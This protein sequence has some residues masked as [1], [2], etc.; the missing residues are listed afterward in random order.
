MVEQSVFFPYR[1]S[2]AGGFFPH[3]E[4]IPDVVVWHTHPGSDGD[5]HSDGP[6]EQHS[7]NQVQ[8]PGPEGVPCRCGSE[9]PKRAG[10]YG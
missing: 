4:E 8:K 5:H 2:Q 6:S 9:F 3:L 1:L 10:L 7:R